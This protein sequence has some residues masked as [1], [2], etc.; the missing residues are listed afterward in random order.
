[1][2]SENANGGSAINV[3]ARCKSKVDFA[4]KRLDV[5]PLIKGLI[6]MSK[7]SD[8]IDPSAAP[9]AD[10]GLV[11]SEVLGWI[12]LGHAYGDDIRNLLKQMTTGENGTAPYYELVYS[13]SMYKWSHN[14]GSGVYALWMV[15]K[16]TPLHIRHSIALAI[17]MR[18]AIRFES[19]QLSVPFAWTTDSGFSAED[20][21]SDLLGFYRVIRPQNYFSQLKLVSKAEAL[22]RWDYYGAT[23]SYK[24][25]L[26]QP[27]LFPDPEKNKTGK[28]FYG[29]LPNFMTSIQPYNDFTRDT[30]LVV[31]NNGV[32]MNIGQQ[33]QER[34]R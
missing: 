14:V 3:M 31:S 12:D 23:G 32:L 19:R 10:F 20:L 15:K 30:V 18:T 24:N 5:F 21:V 4:Y 8:I 34:F 2:K 28:P 17:M 27:L 9:T 33:P 25:K 22:K 11:Y 13:Q 29:E 26:F 1:M 6:I 7:R 16:G